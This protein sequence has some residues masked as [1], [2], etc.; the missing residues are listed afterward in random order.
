VVCYSTPAR[1]V[2]GDFYAYHAFNFSGNSEVP[3]KYALALGDVTGKG[4]PAALL[5]A[6]SL[7]SFRSVVGQGLS[8]TELLAQMN[9]ALIDYTR[10]TYQNCAL[11]YIEI[12]LQG[13]ED[14]EN[15]VGATVRLANAGGIMPLV[16][17]AD[18]TI[19]WVEIGGVPLGTELGAELGY[20]KAELSLA[21]GD[22]IILTSDGLVEANNADND[23]FGFERLE[24]AVKSGPMTSAE[25]MLE[26]LKT[27]I[28]A[29]VGETE[30]HDDLTMVVVRV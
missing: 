26:Y 28:T 14:S 9:Q 23:L 6:V 3:G 7:A 11:V 24:Q 30:A 2:G 25:A 8:P 22:L 10:M 15:L 5:M 20:Q 13:L 4:M 19:R 21:K 1:T 27:T 16:K 17:F 29:F 18:G 12:E